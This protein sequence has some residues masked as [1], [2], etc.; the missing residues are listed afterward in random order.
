MYKYFLWCRPGARLLLL[1][2]CMCASKNAMVNHN[3]TVVKGPNQQ[4]I[5]YHKTACCETFICNYCLSFLW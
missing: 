1:L 4:P 2:S 3:W 5:S